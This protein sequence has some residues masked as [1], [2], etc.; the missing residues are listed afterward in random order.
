MYSLEIAFHCVN[1]MKEKGKT[2]FNYLL[3]K[4]FT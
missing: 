2:D 1:V 3:M 4:T